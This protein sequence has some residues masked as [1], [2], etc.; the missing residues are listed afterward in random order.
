MVFN[1]FGAPDGYYKDSRDEKISTGILTDA[2]EHFDLYKKL[3]PLVNR[4]LTDI[5]AKSKSLVKF[6][7]QS[8]LNSVCAQMDMV[9]TKV[10]VGPFSGPNELY[11][12]ATDIIEE[13]SSLGK[14]FVDIAYGIERY[15]SGKPYQIEFL[16]CPEESAVAL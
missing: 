1:A 5:K 16:Y 8:S 4:E 12:K 14:I 15:G 3:L 11:E 10:S 9:H 13:L 7:H 2:S 6:T